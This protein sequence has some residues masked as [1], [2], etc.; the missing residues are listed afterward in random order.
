MEAGLRSLSILRRFASDQKGNFAILFGLAAIPVVGAIGIAVDYSLANGSRTAMQAALDNTALALS[1]QMP[2]TQAELDDKGWKIFQANLGQTPLT[3]TPSDLV[4]TP[5]V[6]KLSLVLNTKYPIRMAGVLSQYMPIDIPI[7][8][9]VDAVWGL[10]KVEVALALDNTGSMAGSKITQLISASHN[11]VEILKNA[12]LT[13]GDAKVAIIPFGFQTKVDPVVNLDATWLRW[14]L[15]E[16][17]HGSCSVNG[18]NKS[19]C[20]TAHC[21][22]SQYTS[23]SSCQSHSGTWY[24]AGTWTPDNHNT[25]NGCIADRDKNY[26]ADDTGVSSTAT[27]FPAM[28]ECGGLAQVMSLNY[29]WGSPSSVDPTTVHGRINQMVATGNTNVTIGLDWGFQM[30]SPAGTLPF[31]QG[32][33]YNTAN[34]TKYVIILT[35]GDNTQNRFGDSQ[36]VIDERTTLAC[37]NIKAKG[38][39]IYSIRVINGNANLLRNCA[40]DP[41]MYFEVSDAAELAG[42]FNAIGSTIANL[43][44]AK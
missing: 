21:S 25:W 13:P 32:A 12:A 8:S 41:S 14:D 39:M 42:V 36:T 1:K 7:G 34:L 40:T 27:K 17:A 33:A 9:R 18:S 16:A 22:K 19:I 23:Q 26:D 28:Q 5:A 11:L 15:W 10:G 31:S 35:D 20:E 29:N 4:I 44:L 24:S 43:H 2:L 30:V 38:I 3:I 37:T 6:G